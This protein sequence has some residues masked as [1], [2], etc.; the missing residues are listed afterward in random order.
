MNLEFYK[1]RFGSTQ[2]CHHTKL[3]LQTEFAREAGSA[4][5]QNLGVSA[6]KKK[7]ALAPKPKQ[8]S[9]KRY[10]SPLNNSKKPTN[11]Q[12]LSIPDKIITK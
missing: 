12:I 6:H 7:I 9:C 11:T 5:V 10:I 4:Y 3:R 8:D 2:Q 1:D